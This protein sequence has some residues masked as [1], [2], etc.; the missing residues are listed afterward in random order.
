MTLSSS[1]SA[2]IAVEHSMRSQTM[3][4]AVEAAKIVFSSDQPDSRPW[5]TAPPKASPAPRPFL[6]VAGVTGISMRSS[7]VLAR[8][9][10]GP[11][12][13]MASST[14]ASSRASAARSGSVWPTA[15][16]HSSRLPMATVVSGRTAR[17]ASWAVASSGQNMAR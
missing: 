16:R 17:T 13:T 14:P 3:A 10:W 6:V 2:G 5:H 15:T 7:R 11:C 4:P 1:G 8:V 12:L 9:P